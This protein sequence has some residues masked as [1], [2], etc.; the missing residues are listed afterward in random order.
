M[1]LRNSTITRPVQFDIDLLRS[2]ATGM[3]LGSFAKAAD[4]LGRSASAISLQLR[5]LE[6][7]AG[8]TLV[9]KQGRGLVLTEAGE[10]ML[11]Y[12]NRI[13]E[14]HDEAG[15]ALRGFAIEGSVRLGLPQDFAETWLPGLLGR[16]ARAH[17]HVR[18]EARVERSIAMIEAIERGALDLALIWDDMPSAHR[19]LVAMMPSVWIGPAGFKRDPGTA[20]PVVAFDPPCG[21]RKAGIDALDG[22]GIAWRHSFAS[23]SLAALWA[24]V[25][26]GLG[27]TVRSPHGVPTPLKVLDPKESGLPALPPL[28]LFL[29]LAKP[30]PSPAVAR[31]RE[32]LLQTA[33]EELE[34]IAARTPKKKSGSAKR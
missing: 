31:L 10:I 18:V 19:Q 2:F 20:L 7:Q 17:P 3:A 34:P 9:R 22:A 4:R 21:F 29:H 33:S 11:G 32:L 26:G 15:A 6:E 28:P 5:K 16:F 13:L 27:I 1:V 12:A 30:E 23:P 24:A 25:R 8:Q 14:L